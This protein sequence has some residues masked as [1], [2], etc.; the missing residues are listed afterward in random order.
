MKLLRI[1][2]LLATLIGCGGG[3]AA[4]IGES[5]LALS[6]G[7]TA[8]ASSVEI[9]GLEAPKAIDNN[10]ATRWSSAFSDP[11]WITVDM[12]M[13]RSINRVLLTWEAAYGK[14]YQIQISDNNSTWTTLRSLTN[15]NGGTDDITGLTGTGRYLRI[16]GTARGTPYGYSLWE[17][18]I[19]LA[20][21]PDA[22]GT[23]GTGTGGA[24]T[25]GAGTGGAAGADAGIDAET[26]SDA[27]VG[28]TGG[29]GG[30]GGAIGGI[31]GI[32]GTDWSVAMV[33]STLARFPN[34]GSFGGWDYTKTFYFH[35]QYQVWRRTGNMAYINRI[36]DWVDAHVNASGVID[37][38]LN[39]LDNMQGMN[40][41]IDLFNETRNPKYQTAAANIRTRLNTYPRTTMDGSPG[42]WIHQTPL[43][44]QLWADGVF[45]VNP[46]LS[47]YGHTFNDAVYVDNETSRQLL[48]YANHLKDNVTGLY[49]HAYDETGAVSW[50]DPVTHHSPAFWCRAVGWYGVTMVDLL[51]NIDVSHPNRAT[52]LANL[53]ALVTGLANVQDGPSGRW[54]QVMN[55]GGVSGNF[56]E[57]SCSSMHTYV[58][59]KA[60]EK[61]YVSSS[62]SANAAAGHTGVLGR[63]TLNGSNQ[64]DITTIVVGTGPG[65]TDS[66]YFTRP[67]AS[68]DFHGLGAF[69]LMREQLARPTFTATYRWFEA[70]ATATLNAPMGIQTDPLASN[71]NYLTVAA[72]NSNTAGIPTNG[73]VTYTV[74]IPSAGA[75][76]VW[77]R[78]IMPSTN[79]D[80]FSLRFNNAATWVQWN[81]N[82]AFPT[83]WTW[84]IVHDTLQGET[85][86]LWPLSAGNHTLELV[87]REDG[88]KLDKLLVTNDLNYVPTGLGN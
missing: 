29:T 19:F 56:T 88:A 26:G 46:G 73:H 8:T 9:A 75:Y 55:K 1:L 10:G 86:M 76:R 59:S 69:L 7:A 42:A 24:G 83:A 38:G 82:N 80:S 35:Q 31:G 2:P 51:D 5:K 41:L 6:F 22:G 27:E 14:N 65:N 43:T 66:Y 63:I 67:V 44:G 25:G 70:E 47:R 16:F 61:G 17:I 28:E 3:T 60:V 11:Q 32:G 77:G 64:T 72:G 12:Q 87:Y 40:I 33:N 48:I 62:F 58:I 81:N 71:G 34:A 52:L 36:R 78:V 13:Q 18:Q 15:Q 74:N 23:G 53:Q 57:T 4:L 30:A 39:T 54:W 68:N 20:P 50:D 79:D 49:F 85:N 21:P 84:V 37:A 45:M